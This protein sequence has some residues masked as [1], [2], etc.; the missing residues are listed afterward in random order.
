MVAIVTFDRVVRDDVLVRLRVV[1]FFMIRPFQISEI[2]YQSTWS[3]PTN[4][5][6]KAGGSSC[7]KVDFL[8]SRDLSKG[9]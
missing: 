3:R 6:A 8:R 2:R 9:T 1:L 7:Q 5:N 4:R